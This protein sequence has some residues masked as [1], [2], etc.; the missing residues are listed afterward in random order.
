MY[1]MRD[2]FSFTPPADATRVELVLILSGHGQA[3]MTN[4]SEWCDHRH[5]FGVNG[6]DLPE[7]RHEGDIGSAAGCGPAAAF[8]VSP[9]QWGNWAPE[10][11][12]WC[13]GL[14]V[15]HIV[16]DITDQVT[17]GQA[18]DLTYSGN[19]RGGAPGGG[20]IS[21]TSYVTWVR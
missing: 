19:Y 17:L 1:N 8:G 16:V 3:G 9:G 18:N 15:D 14:P 10:R 2:P 12:Y 13:P 7:I 20:N 5:Q 21:L 4:C 6:T 11:A